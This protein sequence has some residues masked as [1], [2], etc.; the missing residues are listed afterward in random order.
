MLP[1]GPPL[2][3]PAADSFFCTRSDLVTRQGNGVCPRNLGHLA[4]PRL[5]GAVH[6]RLHCVEAVEECQVA[7]L[8]VGIDALRYLLGILE[9]AGE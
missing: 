1:E 5:L 6:E 9:G 8:Q 7:L 3:P 4:L 2:P